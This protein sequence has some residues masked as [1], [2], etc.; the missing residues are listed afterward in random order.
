MWSDPTIIRVFLG[1]IFIGLTAAVVGTFAFLHKKSLIGDA[2]SHAVLPGVVL[3][4][5]LSGVRQTWV[6]LLGALI[7]GWI[8]SQQISWVQRVTKLKS[9]AAIA[10]VMSTFFALGL[11][12]LSYLQSKPDDGQAGLSDFLFGKIAALTR[13]D[14][15]LFG[16]LGM[17]ILLIIFFKFRVLFGMAFNKEHLQ[18]LGFS[19]RINDFI[20][21]TLIIL[22][23]SMGIQAVGVVLMSALLIV[24]VASARMLTYRIKWIIVLA[25]IFGVLSALGG[26]MISLSAANMPTGP[27]IIAVLSFFTF[28]SAMWRWRKETLN[29]KK[30][31]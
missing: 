26:S 16:A 18:S 10:S 2:I 23:V 17:L 7:V 6:L 29:Q 24:P 30:N 25:I 31:G 27:W 11:V 3:A 14:V 20:L 13:E 8:A 9:D 1:T 4:Y 22:T 15:V 5:A 21:N 28:I 19:H 12:S